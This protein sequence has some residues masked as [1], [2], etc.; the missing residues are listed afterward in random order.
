METIWTALIAAASAIIG[1]VITGLFLRRKTEAETTD[2]IVKSATS[3]IEPLNKQ[4]ESMQK[5][6]DRQ[7]KII[8]SYGQ[9]MVVLM[10]GIQCLVD[11]I[12]TLG[13]DPCWQPDDWQPAADECSK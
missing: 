3:L 6:L 13:H 4:V 5:Q 11:Q 10:K 8:Q 9:R 7:K 1:A 12:G 2:L